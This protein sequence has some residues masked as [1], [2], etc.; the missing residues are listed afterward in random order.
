MTI[1]GSL[2]GGWRATAVVAAAAACIGCDEG[3][4]AAPAFAGTGPLSGA[5]DGGDA[6]VYVV[7]PTGLEPTYSSILTKMLDAPTCGS[8]RPGNC[9][10]TQGAHDLGHGLDFTLD[11]GA[12]YAELVGDGGGARAANIQG[13]ASVLRVDPRDA[14]ASMLYLK[15]TIDVLTDPRYGAGMPRDAPGSV[16]PA[17]LDAVKTW[18][19]QGAKNN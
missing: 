11:A 8:N 4:A 5:S 3:S 6:A 13:D 7:C 15:L 19:D 14:G 1:A 9:H 16:C 12:V 10:T 17:A 18:I 2:R